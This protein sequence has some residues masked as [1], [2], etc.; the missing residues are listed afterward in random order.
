MECEVFVKNDPHLGT[1]SSKGF[2]N[3]STPSSWIGSAG[4]SFSPTSDSPNLI[5]L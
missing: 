2:H 4:M 3:T 5:R 1:I